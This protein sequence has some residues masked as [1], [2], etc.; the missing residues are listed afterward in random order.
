MSQEQLEY[1]YLRPMCLLNEI[2]NLL[3]FKCIDLLVLIKYSHDE[4]SLNIHIDCV[5][6]MLKSGQ[7]DNI[8]WLRACP[9]SMQMPRI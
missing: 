9:L 3:L 1:R 5:T 8:S 7:F 6:K 2:I 4:Q